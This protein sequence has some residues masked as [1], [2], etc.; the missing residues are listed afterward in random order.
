MLDTVGCWLDAPPTHPP[1]CRYGAEA[2]DLCLTAI[3]QQQF[4][5]ARKRSKLNVTVPVPE[6]ADG[7]I[8]D[9]ELAGAG[10]APEQTAEKRFY[11]YFRAR[12]VSCLGWDWPFVDAGERWHHLRAAV[13]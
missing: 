8:T 6:V 7:F 11:Q 1:V 3:L 13:R 2:L 10:G 4:G 9:A 12:L 5:S